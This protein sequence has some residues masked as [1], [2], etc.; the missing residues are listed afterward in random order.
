M[1]YFVAFV[2][3]QVVTHPAEIYRFPIRLSGII[4]FRLPEYDGS[5][6]P[7]IVSIVRQEVLIYIPEQCVKCKCYA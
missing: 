4:L 5:N 6:N 2:L 3:I 7:I 1:L